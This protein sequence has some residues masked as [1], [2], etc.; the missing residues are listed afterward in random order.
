MSG[1]PKI[2][3]ADTSSIYNMLPHGKRFQVLKSIN[4]IDTEIVSK[5]NIKDGNLFSFENKGLVINPLAIESAFQAMGLLDI[6][7]SKKLGLP[8]GIKSITIRQSENPPFIVR[9]IKTADTE[10]GSLYNFQVLT[11]DGEVLFNAENYSTVQIETTADLSVVEKIKLNQ[12]KQLFSLPKG[13]ALEVVDVKAIK[14]KLKDDSFVQEILRQDEIEKL[15]SYEVPKRKVE[16]FSGVYAAKL[17]V[18][19]IKPDVN[20]HEV[21]IEKTALGK[22]SIKIGKGK[23]QIYLSITHSNGFAV[24]AVNL[25][26]DIGID[27]E[28]IEKRSKSLVDEV[29]SPVEK[30]QILKSK[31]EIADELPTKIW[32]AKE[33]ASKV[34]G[35]G[36]NVDLHHLQISALKDKSITMDLNPQIISQLEKK[37]ARKKDLQLTA[38]IANNDEYVAAVCLFQ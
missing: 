35:V 5:T 9:G 31:K 32:T 2:P 19:Q 1:L 7:K 29:I 34:L 6:V 26:L 11:K 33:A 38:N 18:K 20:Y 15:N 14:K 23:S 37:K 12:I 13:T 17:A 16:W 10:Y 30:D 25:D 4:K 36:L 28:I 3:L 8:S 22:P 27:L 24:A 21:F